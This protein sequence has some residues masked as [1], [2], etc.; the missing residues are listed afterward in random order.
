MEVLAHAIVVIIVQY[1]NASN[2]HIA[3]L[4]FIQLSV[5]GGKSKELLVD[6]G[7]E[8]QVYTYQRILL[9]WEN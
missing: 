7:E 6:G 3:H 4:K 1:I 5:I 9:F 2:Q 8:E